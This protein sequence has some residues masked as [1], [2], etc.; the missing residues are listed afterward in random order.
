MVPRDDLSSSEEM[1]AGEQDSFVMPI[2]ESI[3]FHS[4]D[5][6]SN[7]SE[8]IRLKLNTSPIGD[9]QDDDSDYQKN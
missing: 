8:V 3:N 5:R 6:K 9:G 4:S 7:S 1:S 2:N